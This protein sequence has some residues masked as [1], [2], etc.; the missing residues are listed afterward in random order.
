MGQILSKLFGQSAAISESEYI[1]INSDIQQKLEDIASK[2]L[3][4]DDSQNISV[5]DGTT[6]EEVNKLYEEANDLIKNIDDEKTAAIRDDIDA[7]YQNYIEQELK[8]IVSKLKSDIQSIS[9]PADHASRTIAYQGILSMISDS[10]SKMS[11]LLNSYTR[12]RAVHIDEINELKQRYT[13]LATNSNMD[14][15]YQQAQEL[16]C[17]IAYGYGTSIK[18]HVFDESF[19][20]SSLRSALTNYVTPRVSLA[21]FKLLLQISEFQTL[22]WPVESYVFY[23]SDNNRRGYLPSDSEYERYLPTFVNYLITLMEYY[24]KFYYKNVNDTE[25]QEIDALCSGYLGTALNEH[26]FFATTKSFIRGDGVSSMYKW[27]ALMY[28]SGK[29]AIINNKLLYLPSTF[30]KYYYEFEQYEAMV[31]IINQLYRSIGNAKTFERIDMTELYDTYYSPIA[32]DL[33]TMVTVDDLDIERFK[34]LW[35]VSKTEIHRLR[36][37][38][39][40]G[41]PID[42]NS[43]RCF[44]K[45]SIAATDNSTSVISDRYIAGNNTE[46]FIKIPKFSAATEDGNPNFDLILNLVDELNGDT[47]ATTLNS[48]ATSANRNIFS[49]IDYMCTTA[50]KSDSGENEFTYWVYLKVL[51][52]SSYWNF[53][54][55]INTL[56][57]TM[58]IN[59]NDIQNGCDSNYLAQYIMYRRPNGKF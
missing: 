57:T 37:E 54:L 27:K 11:T 16:V 42:Y 35:N 56:R 39:N 44:L 6:F 22:A 25:F 49:S 14:M 32:W 38:I 36:S 19:S 10:E 7:T 50:D 51:V 52:N 59:H 31:F 28:M 12:D 53:I 24:S 48:R 15:I 13:L 18:S 40:A 34:S 41:A 20:D 58:T 30:P 33:K 55:P 3:H 4:V 8:S 9:I 43:A 2:T 47:N 23:S 46:T 45:L 17:C 29:N 1:E 26:T 21:T 5:N